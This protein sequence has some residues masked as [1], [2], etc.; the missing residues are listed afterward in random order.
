[1]DY[2]DEE[3]ADFAL[4]WQSARKPHII[5]DW[6]KQTLIWCS[7]E[8]KR[9]CPSTLS[10]LNLKFTKSSLSFQGYLKCVSNFLKYQL[11]ITNNSPALAALS[12]LDNLGILDIPDI[13]DIIDLL[14]YLDILDI[15][16]IIGTIDTLGILDIQDIMDILGKSSVCHTVCNT[17]G[18]PMQMQDKKSPQKG[19]WVQN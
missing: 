3:Y 1:M 14:D 7:Y 6:K 19:P 8:S 10:R 4:V 13:M 15:R 12:I 18:K 9:L 5:A 2:G 11:H 17:S 16:D